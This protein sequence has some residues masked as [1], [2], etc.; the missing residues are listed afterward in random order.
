MARPQL[1]ATARTLGRS[2]W[3]VFCDL[4]ASKAPAQ[5]AQRCSVR[6]VLQTFTFF[7][8]REDF[9][10]SSLVTCH[11]SLSASSV[12]ALL[13]WVAV[14]WSGRPSSAQ[15]SKCTRKFVEKCQEA[16]PRN[17]AKLNFTTAW[18]EIHKRLRGE[19]P[20][21]LAIKYLTTSLRLFVI[22]PPFLGQKIAC[23]RV[24]KARILTGP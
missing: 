5:S 12:A 3:E 6:S 19:V 18:L 2:Q 20:R 22:C 17:C 11:S 21:K 23:L 9:S 15:R 24:R 8:T 7:A 4:R 10:C 1:S 16:V 13:R 14:C